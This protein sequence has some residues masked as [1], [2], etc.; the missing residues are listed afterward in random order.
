MPVK[1]SKQF[2]EIE[3]R[4]ICELAWKRNSPVIPILEMLRNQEPE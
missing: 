3:Q 4:I 2:R 1:I